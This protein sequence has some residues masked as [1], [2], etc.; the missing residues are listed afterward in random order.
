MGNLWLKIWVWVKSIV[1]ALITLYVL[2]FTLQN[3]DQQVKVWLWFGEP[4]QHSLLVVLVLTL[5]LGIVG[6]ILVRTIFR[7]V[8]QIRELRQR[9]RTDKLE[10]EILDMKT[11]AAMLNTRP[12]PPVSSPL[13]ASD[14]PPPVV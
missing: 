11:K 9:S 13:P 14:P 5:L 12:E 4:V 8:K 10:R 3:A 7:T 6:T 2:L 1:L